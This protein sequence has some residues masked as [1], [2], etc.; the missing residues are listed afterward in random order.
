[1]G[2]KRTVVQG[3][4]SQRGVRTENRLDATLISLR[5]QSKLLFIKIGRLSSV[6]LVPSSDDAR[7]GTTFSP[8]APVLAVKYI[9]Y[10]EFISITEG[11]FQCASFNWLPAFIIGFNSF[12]FQPS[13]VSRFTVLYILSVVQDNIEIT[14]IIHNNEI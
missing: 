2:V 4:R 13:C 14:R 10:V 1:M 9:I 11:A 7:K 6:Q 8:G 3:L 12:A 5:V